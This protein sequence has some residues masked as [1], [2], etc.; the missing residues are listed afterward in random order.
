MQ[1]TIN[2]VATPLTDAQW[3]KVQECLKATSCETGNGG[4]LTIGLAWDGINPWRQ[5]S[6]A[7]T[8]A[9]AI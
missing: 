8:T 7:E 2:K 1:R 9:A 3:S 5:T 4:D 6:R